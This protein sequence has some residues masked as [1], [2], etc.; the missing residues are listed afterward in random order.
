[1]N[2][3]VAIVGVG[4]GSGG[5]PAAV[6]QADRAAMHAASVVARGAAWSAVG[7]REDAAALRYASAAGAGVVDVTDDVAQV[8]FDIA[9]VGSGARIELGD[10]L[11]ARLA[12]RRRAAMVVD[13]LVVEVA[14]DSLRVTRDLGRGASEVLHVASPA[15]LVMSDDAPGGRYVSRWRLNRASVGAITASSA[16]RES[17][18]GRWEAARPRPRVAAS[19]VPAGTSTDRLNEVMGATEPS[20]AAGEEQSLV[21]GDAPALA[22]YLLRYLAHHGF[23]HGAAAADARDV[24]AKSLAGAVQHNAASSLPAETSG[25]FE[26]TNARLARSPRSLTGASRGYRRRP[27]PLGNTTPFIPVGI[28]RGPRGLAGAAEGMRRR[29]RSLVAQP[30]ATVPRNSLDAAL[31]G[32]VARRPRPLGAASPLKRRGPVLLHPSSIHRTN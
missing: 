23:I 6:P 9:L 17:V 31:S 14:G 27:R 13:V 4:A 28:Q 16:S 25:L 12:E 22:R 8:D 11:P 15:V 10:L 26:P 29:P 18:A 30:S 3:V 2:R 21:L 20:A 1:M 24:A 19:S 7:G 32:Q 5:G